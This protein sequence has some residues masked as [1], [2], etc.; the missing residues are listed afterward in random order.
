SVSPAGSTYTYD[1][2]SNRVRKVLPGND[3]TEYIYFGGQIISEQKQNGE[4][5]DYIY[6]NGKRIAKADTFEKRIHIPATNS[7]NCGWQYTGYDLPASG[8]A[9]YVIRPG[10]TLRLRQWQ[11]PNSHG[12]ITMTFVGGLSTNWALNDQDQQV[13]NSDNSQ[14]TW[15]YRIFDLTAASSDYT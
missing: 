5:V 6:A 3:W 2:D 4:M 7:P 14:N 9:G 15:H 10:D 11:T 13:A 1:G 8:Y 12:G